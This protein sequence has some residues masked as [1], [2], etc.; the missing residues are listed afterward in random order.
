MDLLTANDAAV[1]VGVSPD[2]IRR[3]VASGR[4]ASV[5]QGRNI[6]IPRE[7]AEKLVKQCMGCHRK[8]VPK[9]A[10]SVSP[11][12]PACARLGKAG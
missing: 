5:R 1:I 7:S 3:Y 11:Y 2:L 9:S 8:F 6:L 4:L 12:C 10:D